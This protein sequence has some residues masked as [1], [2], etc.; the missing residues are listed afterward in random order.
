[1][2]FILLTIT[3]LA[4]A[5][6]VL[7]GCNTAAPL[8]ANNERK[9]TETTAPKTDNHGPTDDAPRITLADAKK[10]FDNGT[11]VFVDT[12]ADILYRTEHVK[13]AIS[14]PAEAAEQ[15]YREIPTDKKIIAYCS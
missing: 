10:D 4:V 11:A 6:G 9:T 7:L 14:I 8:K 13:G 1:M 12:R 2:R 15:R 3:L 5:A